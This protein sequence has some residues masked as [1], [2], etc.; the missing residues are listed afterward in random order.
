M[1][2]RSLLIYCLVIVVILLQLIV[3]LSHLL[4]STGLLPCRRDLDLM[5]AS[6]ASYRRIGSVLGQMTI[7]MT[8]PI[9][10][11]AHHTNFLL[12]HR[13]F[14][15]VVTSTTGGAIPV[16]RQLPVDEVPRIVWV[17]G[18]PGSGKGTQCEMLFK[19]YGPS[20][21][22]SIP[23]TLPTPPFPLTEDT[24]GAVATIPWYMSFLSVGDL[25]RTELARYKSGLGTILSTEAAY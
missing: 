7:P 18:G 19:Q 5:L 12:H 21:S 15:S 23:T 13:T 11:L 16:A 22:T 4:S 20:T 1:H 10:C 25:L 6:S 3:S 9:S 2:H 24:K 8:T 14:A 17:N